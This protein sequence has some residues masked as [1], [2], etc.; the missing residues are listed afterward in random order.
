[1]YAAAQGVVKVMSKMGISTIQSYRG[2]QIFEA[3]GI[4]KEVIDQHFT[5]TASQLGGIDLQTIG[6]EARRRHTQ[7]LASGDKGLPPGSEYQWRANGEH[8][9][10]IHI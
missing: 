1:M 5:G 7:A 4:A 6:E 8:L 9:S 3:V 2:A 10:L